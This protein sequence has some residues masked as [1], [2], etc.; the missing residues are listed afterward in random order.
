MA[1]IALSLVIVTST[2]IV[3]ENPLA[4]PLNVPPLNSD[5]AHPVIMPIAN[6]AV[7]KILVIFFI[8]SS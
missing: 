1:S 6:N 8:I 2:L 5:F 4:S 3:D 7:S